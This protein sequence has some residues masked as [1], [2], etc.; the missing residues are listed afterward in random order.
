[1]YPRQPMRTVD[2]VMSVLFR[3]LP[4]FTVKPIHCLR[5]IWDI[6]SE[7]AFLL[8]RISANNVR[9]NWYFLFIPLKSLGLTSVSV[10]QS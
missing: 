8:Y 1:M 7:N 6:Y 9:G 2:Y 3:K 10:N 5:N 4:F